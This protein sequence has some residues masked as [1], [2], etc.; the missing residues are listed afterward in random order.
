M[1]RPSRS[2]T[3]SIPHVPSQLDDLLLPYRDNW[4]HGFLFTREPIHVP[5]LK[6]DTF[7]SNALMG[8]LQITQ[9]DFEDA[10]MATSIDA[11]P[12]PE[13]SLSDTYHFFAPTVNIHPVT[14]GFGSAKSK[15][16]Y[17]AGDTPN[18]PPDMAFDVRFALDSTRGTLLFKY[19]CAET[20]KTLLVCIQKPSNGTVW[21]ETRA[22]FN[23]TAFATVAE[24]DTS[25]STNRLLPHL[26]YFSVA[27]VARVT[28]LTTLSTAPSQGEIVKSRI[29]DSTP[30]PIPAHPFDFSSF[31]SE[32]PKFLGS[33]HG[34]N[35]HVAFYNNF[36]VWSH[37]DASRKTVDSISN[38]TLLKHL[39]D[40]ALSRHA[41]S[42]NET[43]RSDLSLLQTDVPPEH[44][45]HT[46]PVN[47]TQ[48]DAERIFDVSEIGGMEIALALPPDQSAPST[49]MLF[50]S[51]IE[52]LLYDGE[53]QLDSNGNSERA[54][55]GQ[56]QPREGDTLAD[57]M[58][59]PHLE[60]D[61]VTR[62]EYVPSAT[63]QDGAVAELLP[64]SEGVSTNDSYEALH[65]SLHAAEPNAEAGADDEIAREEAE[66]LQERQRI[67]QARRERNRASARR[68]N[69]RIKATRERLKSDV[70]EARERVSILQTREIQLRKENLE[71][72]KL[73]F[74]S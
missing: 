25:L 74:G 17:A 38:A 11:A 5:Y 24:G 32:T 33:F 47:S 3:H 18:L 9:L 51:L 46:T 73:A 10:S 44:G 19:D 52:P 7:M 68:A 58:A 1:I 49:E 53:L 62:R 14:V 16:R 56:S 67:L 12:G 45:A 27:S 70:D 65:L 64:T 57:D 20:E 41:Y 2:Y 39:R 23:R 15:I 55:G 37:I 48:T 29:P 54:R 72:R 31:Q 40:A 59:Q 36:P 35:N 42:M 50:H 22:M 4:L 8:W 34:S 66:K 6:S 69:A 60:T 21:T 71:L 61:S 26:L 28:G 13:T 30:A 63:G 43:P